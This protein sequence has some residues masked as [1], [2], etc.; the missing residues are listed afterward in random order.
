MAGIVA[1]SWSGSMF[2]STLENFIPNT[3]VKTKAVISGTKFVL[4]FPI[5][6]VEYTSNVGIGVVEKIF[7]GSE[8]PTN[9]TEVFKLNQG[10][11]LKNIPTFRK[12]LIGWVV[13][14]LNELK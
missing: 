7:F 12:P 10:P 11:K 3:M 13:N 2:L 8:L 4:A 5:R 6:C 9:T 1:L 14:R